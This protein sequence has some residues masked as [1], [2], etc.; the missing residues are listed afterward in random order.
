[1]LSS[2]FLLKLP[3][4]MMLIEKKKKKKTKILGYLKVNS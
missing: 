3:N 2:S 1:M 4:E